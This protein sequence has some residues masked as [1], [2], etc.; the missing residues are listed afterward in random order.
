MFKHILV[1]T[2]GSPLADRA[3]ATALRLARTCGRATRVTALMVV[4]DYG[5]F[6]VVKV[7]LEDGPSLDVLRERFAAEARRRLDQ[8]LRQHGSSERAEPEV[9]VSDFPYDEIVKTAQRLPCD[10]VVIAARGRGAMK[11]AVLGSQ[12]SHVLTLAKIPVLV[13]K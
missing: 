6:D 9:A 11:S 1:A 13:V 3:I 5:T 2:D 7:T 10:L 8:V 12:T 4:P